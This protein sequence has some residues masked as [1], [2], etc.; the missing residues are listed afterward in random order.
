MKITKRQLRK[1]VRKV[2]VEQHP[3]PYASATGV[4]SNEYQRGYNDGMD[5]EPADESADIAYHD[6]YEDALSDEAKR[7]RQTYGV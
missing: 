3:S 7:E 6:G 2:L 5:G 1:V 4:E